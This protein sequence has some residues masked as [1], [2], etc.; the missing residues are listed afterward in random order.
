MNV[1]PLLLPYSPSM[2]SLISSGLPTSS[3]RTACGKSATCTTLENEG[4]IRPHQ[5]GE[6][7]FSGRSTQRVAF[8]WR[9]P[10]EGVYGRR[11][12]CRS[13]AFKHPHVALEDVA[14]YGEVAAVR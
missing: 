6:R 13:E 4:R 3:L 7:Q 9:F 2:L 10:V 8:L 12:S 14:A 5:S 11:P 1:F